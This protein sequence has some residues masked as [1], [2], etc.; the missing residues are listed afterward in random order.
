MKIPIKNALICAEFAS[1]IHEVFMI[2]ELYDDRHLLCQYGH[3]HSQAKCIVSTLSEYI[4]YI[5]LLN[6][7]RKFTCIIKQIVYYF[8][9][10]A[11]S[12]YED[13]QNHRIYNTPI[14]LPESQLFLEEFNLK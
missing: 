14:S 1:N 11:Y 10:I 2:Q 6:V 7:D 3:Y 8:I 5:L 13:I 4:K 12:I 9:D